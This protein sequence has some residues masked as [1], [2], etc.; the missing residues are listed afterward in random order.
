MIGGEY[1]GSNNIGSV[2]WTDAYEHGAAC[3]LWGNCLLLIHCVEVRLVKA[4]RPC[5]LLPDYR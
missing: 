2:F 5:D 4:I 1:D 3:S